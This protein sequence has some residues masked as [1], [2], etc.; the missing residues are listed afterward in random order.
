MSS[1]HPADLD[2]G[3]PCRHD[4]GLRLHF[5]ALRASV[6]LV[7]TESS[8]KKSVVPIAPEGLA[9]PYKPNSNSIFSRSNPTT[10]SPSIRV[11]GV[12]W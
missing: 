1:E 8:D 10:A 5:H 7:R 11:T 9:F 4:E 6:R 12:L 2:A 3:H